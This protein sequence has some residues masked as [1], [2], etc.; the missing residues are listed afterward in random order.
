M[1][2][3]TFRSAAAD[4]LAQA[5]YDPKKL[6][7][8]HTG[9]SLLVS[10]LLTLVSHL[11]GNAIDGAGGLANLGNRAILSTI[12][13]VL[14]TAVMLLL[15]FWEIGF[16]YAALRMCRSRDA[17][18]RDLPEGFRR[19]GPIVRL[20]LLEMGITFILVFACMQLASI[21][22]AFTPFMENVVEAMK[23]ISQQANSAKLEMLTEKELMAMLPAL[24]PMYVIF[25]IVLAAIGLPIFYRFRLSRFAILD[26]AGGA[27]KALGISAYLTR[28]NKWKLMKLDLQFW[29]YYGA[30]LLIAAITYTDVL[31]QA[32]GI[33]LPV[34]GTVV[35]FGSYAVHMVLR[36]LLAWQFGSQVQA[37]YAHCYDYLKQNPPA[38]PAPKQLPEDVPWD[39]Q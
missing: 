5:S 27:R 11:L 14:S 34:S 35:F 13:S 3:K 26:D 29:W 28:G 12:Q 32:M 31:L 24:I 23:Q 22:F 8:I 18:P 38:A 15:P 7:L 1:D 36:L 20:Y 10:L 21:L 37:T 4:S 9:V 33:T 25:L 17:Q 19:F 6:A 39:S 2:F 16:L 30:Q